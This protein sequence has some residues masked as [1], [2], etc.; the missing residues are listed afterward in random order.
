VT[1]LDILPKGPA[2]QPRAGGVETHP[3]AKRRSQRVV[4]DVPVTVFGQSSSGKIFT[5]NTK[6]VTVNAH[7]ALVTLNVDIDPQKSALLL[8]AKTGTQV[9]CRVAYRKETKKGCFDVGLEFAS[10]NPKL[11][12]ITFPPEDWNPADRKKAE[13]PT[14]KTV[15]STK[16]LTK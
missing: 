3:S 13:P 1:T 15:S 6:T 14:M 2:V 16:G 11:W 9:Q 10:P 12:G 8:H 7:G 5:E 4:I